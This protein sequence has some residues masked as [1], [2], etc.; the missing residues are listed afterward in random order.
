MCIAYL[1][2][3]ENPHWPLF[4]AANRDEFHRRDALPAA[5]WPED[6]RVIAGRDLT[7]GGT[8][9]GWASCHR[10][11]LLTNFRDPG[12]HRDDRRSRG[13]LVSDFLLGT[14]TPKEYAWQLHQQADD[15]NGFNL[16]VGQGLQAWDV[17]DHTDSAP[18][19]L[20]PGSDALS[21]H[22]LDT[23]WPKVKRL[24]EQ[25]DGLMPTDDKLN[26]DSVYQTLRD[27][28]RPND[29]A[30]PRTGIPLELE[31][32]LS[33]IFIVSPDYGTRCSTI[34]AV[35]PD[36]SGVFSET[37]YNNKGQ[38][39]ERHDWPLSDAALSMPA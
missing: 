31:K 35:G 7:A 11:G 3:G 21:N 6:Q 23:P 28:S 33:S 5:P 26:L 19:A 30:L 24:R 38:P 15:Y 29:E 17:G 9:L 12:A 25:L 20:G 22:A 36:G 1:S 18:Q 2:L 27:G 8:W 37:S 32:L 13:H 34:I 14:I 39:V 16:L 4:I 10:W